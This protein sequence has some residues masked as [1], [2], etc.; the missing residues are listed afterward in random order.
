[1]SVN[2]N[3]IWKK[4]Q[5]TKSSPGK[6]ANTLGI[7]KDWEIISVDDDDLNEENWKK[8]EDKIKLGKKMKIKFATNAIVNSISFFQNHSE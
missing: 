2:F 8:I 1:M 6:Q 7:Q 3:A 5:I 4:W